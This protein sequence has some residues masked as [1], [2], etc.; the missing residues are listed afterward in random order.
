MITIFNG[1]TCTQRRYN[2]VSMQD[3]DF[4]ML[5]TLNIQG[6]ESAWKNQRTSTKKS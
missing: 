6:M 1:Y 5:T 2:S 3:I 4:N